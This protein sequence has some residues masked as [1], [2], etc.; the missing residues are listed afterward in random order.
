MESADVTD[1]VLAT[2]LLR[3]CSAYVVRH[4]ECLF[5]RLGKYEICANLSARAR[6]ESD[7]DVAL[8]DIFGHCEVERSKRQLQR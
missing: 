6:S 5:W 1:D 7:I 2:M 4:T 8:P 3:D